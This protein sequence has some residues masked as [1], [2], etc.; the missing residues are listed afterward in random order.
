M[1]RELSALLHERVAAWIEALPATRAAEL[2]EVAG[3]HLEQAHAARTALGRLDA[4]TAQLAVRAAVKLS[5]AGRRALARGDAPA[6]ASLL[7]RGAIL[8]RDDDARRLELAPQLALALLDTGELARAGR[9]LESAL[10]AAKTLCDD[11]A[12]ARLSVD[13]VGVQLHTDRRPGRARWTPP[14]QRSLRSRP[15]AT[16]PA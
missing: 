10:E 6:A 5:E 13:L 16:T 2:E 12:C 14:R 4:E 9:V 15:P 7:T 8:L 1:P 3:Y 11:Q